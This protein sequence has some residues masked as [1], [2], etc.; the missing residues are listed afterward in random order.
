MVTG[1]CGSRPIVERSWL[2]TTSSDSLSCGGRKCD[3]PS[4][5]LH[6]RAVSGRVCV[7]SQWRTGVSINRAAPHFNLCPHR[8]ERASLRC[9]EHVNIAGEFHLV[10]V[11]VEVHLLPRD[12]VPQRCDIAHTYI[13]TTTTHRGRKRPGQEFC[14]SYVAVAGHQ[15]FRLP[16]C[17]FWKPYPSCPAVP[18]P[19]GSH[20]RRAKC[21][22]PAAGPH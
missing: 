10:V 17:G 3:P 2:E 22:W 19:A 16:S 6:S 9:N 18:A 12:Q 7:V 5:P 20:P 4:P 15:V 1:F 8:Q 11:K 13:T 21:S 14:D